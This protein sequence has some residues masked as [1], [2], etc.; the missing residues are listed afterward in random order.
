MQ[1]K[2][3]HKTA[4]PSVLEDTVGLNLRLAS[5]DLVSDVKKRPPKSHFMFF[6]CGALLTPKVLGAVSTLPDHT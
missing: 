2:P 3:Q 5:K 1:N 6:R 4:R